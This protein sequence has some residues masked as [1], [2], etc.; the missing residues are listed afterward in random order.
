[1]QRSTEICPHI[2]IISYTYWWYC[3]KL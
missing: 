2:F 3:E 1:M